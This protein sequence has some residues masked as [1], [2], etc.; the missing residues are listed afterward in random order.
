MK[1]KW[2]MFAFIVLS[3]LTGCWDKSELEETGFVVVLGIDKGPKPGLLYVTYQVANPQ[4]MSSTLSQSP[5]EPSSDIVT[6][7]V[8]GISSGEDAANTI[9]PRKINLSHCSM[10][11]I[12]SE[13]AQSGQLDRVLTSSLRE[14]ELRRETNV[15][16]SKEPAY[17]FIQNNK[18][19]METRP[20]KYYDFMTRRWKETGMVP[21]ASL[22]RYME[23]R[24]TTDTILLTI[25]ATTKKE[26][27]NYNGGASQFTAGQ[28][29]EKS[30]DPAQII[31]S[32]VLKH[33]KMIGTLTGDET[34]DTLVL[35]KHSLANAWI[36]TFPDPGNKNYDIT[37]RAYKQKKTDIDID[38]SQPIP[39]IH[40]T[41][42]LNMEIV[43]IPSK[44][45][46]VTDLGEQEKLKQ[47]LEKLLTELSMK[48]IKKTQTEYKDEPFLWSIYAR[49]KFMTNAAY[50][51]YHWKEK[52]PEADVH[53]E[54]KIKFV[55]FGKQYQPAK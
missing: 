29:P 6:I 32:A 38:V 20:H 18:P 4:A 51:A 7:A 11:V 21:F 10:I 39:K 34:R 54:Y 19:L 40:V 35:R 36:T 2:V 47:E 43:S 42:P 28:I 23:R 15:I 37:L 33:G 17:Q 25:L 52:Y 26:E 24:E 9:V 22:N 13:L 3:L 27:P 30:G 48:L 55:K 8:P 45:N 31:G 12:G 46:Y 16:V 14:I 50:K 5:N 41:V 44:I 49:S 1:W 53:V